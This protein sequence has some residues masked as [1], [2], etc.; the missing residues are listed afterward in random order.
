MERKCFYYD[1][2]VGD[3]NYIFAT[4]KMYLNKNDFAH[5]NLFH[6]LLWD[7]LY[8][9]NHKRYKIMAHNLQVICGT[10]HELKEYFSTLNKEKTFNFSYFPFYICSLYRRMNNLKLFA[11]HIAW[12]KL[13]FSVLLS[14][15]FFDP[16]FPPILFC[17]KKLIAI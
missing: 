11:V 13:S 9:M 6:F 1:N 14:I 17:K 12:A 10:V 15:N 4:C 16:S 3:E 7:L 5:I 8:T 2:H